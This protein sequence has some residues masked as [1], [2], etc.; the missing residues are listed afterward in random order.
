MSSTT[1]DGVRYE[2]E[3][4]SNVDKAI[5]YFSNNDMEAYV[6][7]G[8]VYIRVYGGSDWIEVQISTA[9]IDYRAELYDDETEVGNV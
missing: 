1:R 5:K 2:V 6:D 7:D 4:M 9:E 3:I 8:S